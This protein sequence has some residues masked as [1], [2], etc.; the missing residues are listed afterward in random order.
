M[1]EDLAL[2]SKKIIEYIKIIVDE[3]DSFI[4]DRVR[5]YLK[6]KMQLVKF[7][8]T[9]TIS[10]IVIKNVLYLPKISY[11]IFPELKKFPNYNIKPKDTVNYDDYLKTNTTYFDYID[12]V[13]ECGLNPLDYFLESLL[14][15]AMHICGSYGFSPLEEGITELKTRE[16]AQKRKILISGMGYPKEVFVAKKFQEVADKDIMDEL[17]FIPVE[18]RYYFLYKKKNLKI[19]NLYQDVSNSMKRSFSDFGKQIQIISDPFQK[20]EVYKRIDYSDAL[21][22]I[23]KYKNNKYR[24]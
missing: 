9:N 11:N 1:E 15:E 2:I 8:E 4:N 16:L 21:D 10:F 18:E 23:D 3:Y 20:A 24:R 13:I 14:H 7:S 19:A 5:F 12:H 17:T 22:L 6:N